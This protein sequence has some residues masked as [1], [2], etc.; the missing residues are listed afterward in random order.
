MRGERGCGEEAEGG[1]HAPHTTGEAGHWHADHRHSASYS[2]LCEHARVQQS[3]LFR[4][5]ESETGEPPTWL[6]SPLQE[7]HFTCSKGE[8]G[9]RRP[10]RQIVPNVQFLQNNPWERPLAAQAAT[11]PAA[12]Y[13]A[14]PFVDFGVQIV[15]SADVSS[16]V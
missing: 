16:L 6:L 9:K 1:P 3:S 14:S 8:N 15:F 4:K 12:L 13:R 2:S 11:D 10:F 5:T 7:H